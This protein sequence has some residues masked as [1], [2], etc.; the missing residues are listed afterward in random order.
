[1]REPGDL[2]APGL[3][4]RAVAAARGA[5]PFDRLLAGG[6]VAD[7]ALGELR[8]ADVGL[9]GPLIASVH[10]PGSRRDAAEVIPV[11]GGIVAPGLIDTH[12]HIESSMVTPAVYAASVLPRG[13]TTLVWDPHELANV[14]GVAGLEFALRAVAALPLRVLLLVPS[15]VP[16][17]PGFER[18]GAEFGAG[19]IAGQLARPEF[20]GLAEV[21]DMAGLLAGDARMRG[22]VQAGLRS[23]KLVCGH[24][25]GLRGGELQAYV[26]AGIGSDHELES[27]ADLLERLR[28]GLTIELRGSH[29]QLLPEFV[30]ALAGLP[31]FP[32]T[33]T[34]CTDDVFPDELERQGGL[35]QLLRR[36]VEH[37][38]PPLH[39]LRAATCNAAT[40][41]GRDDLGRVA[42]GRRADLVVYRD[43]AGFV[44]E[45]VLCD[46]RRPE[47][48]PAG[49]AP[50][51]PPPP[52]RNPLAAADFEV[53]ARGPAARVHTIDRPR[54]TRWGERRLPVQG[55]VLAPPEDVLRMTVLHRHG[56]AGGAGPRNGFLTGW[57]VWR[58]AFATSVSHDSHNL[59]VFGRAPSDMALAAAAVLEDGGGMA[60]AAG[61]R[62]LARLPLPVAGLVSD[63]PLARVAAGFRAVRSAAEAVAGGGRFKF[64]V[65]ASLACNP[66]PRLTDRGIADPLAGRLEESSLIEDGLAP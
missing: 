43:L 64:L 24:A 17:A 28:A 53:A 57:G 48:P 27:G 59:T 44:P 56:R 30:A 23:G 5:A 22:I 46:G 49:A 14:A 58:G 39:A 42:P 7:V 47:F 10:P 20:A 60:V 1:M 55:G 50:S 29:P 19:D 4:A 34:L 32:S 15:C 13:V 31:A 2:H 63:A 61:G 8:P 33:L 16:S 37:G 21:M 25:R 12:L 18:A 6:R 26:A 38:L 45:L 40:R 62:L 3:R 9:V 35:D 66:G 51:L 41:L 65:G 52:P 54:F 11:A 36:L